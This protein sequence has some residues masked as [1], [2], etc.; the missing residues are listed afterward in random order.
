MSTLSLSLFLLAVYG[1][2]FVIC[3]AE[4][5]AVPRRLV[6]RIR[7]FRRLLTCHFCTGFWV[8]GLLYGVSHGSAALRS[9]GSLL[10]ILAGASAAYV[11]D[12]AVLAVEIYISTNTKPP[13]TD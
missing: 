9:S 12:R 13:S 11:V 6:S 5:T 8:A 10:H 1:L 2:T 3:D 7:F 4:I